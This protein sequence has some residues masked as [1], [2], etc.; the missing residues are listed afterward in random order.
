[1]R[2]GHKTAAGRAEFVKLWDKWSSIVRK[3]VQRLTDLATFAVPLRHGVNNYITPRG[4]APIKAELMHWL[5]VKDK[6]GKL[7]GIDPSFY[8]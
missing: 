6:I 7:S 2:T 8:I 1:M 3:T 4:Y 5:D